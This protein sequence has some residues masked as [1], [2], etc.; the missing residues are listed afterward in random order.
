MQ[1]ETL[2]VTGMTCGGCSSKVTK[3]LKALSGVSDVDV[4]LAT[5]KAT[6]QFDE[7]KTSPDQLKSAVKDAG[8]G[9]DL[10]NA[11]HS[12]QSKGGCCS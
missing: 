2:K 10:A 7:Q 3:A 11:T 8:Y 9:V 5:G 6:V 12:H 1:T 4:S